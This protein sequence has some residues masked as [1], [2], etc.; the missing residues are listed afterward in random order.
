[1]DT[2]ITNQNIDFL[3]IKLANMKHEFKRL[4]QANKTKTIHYSYN[5][6]RLKTL[7]KNIKDLTLILESLAPTSSNLHCTKKSFDSSEA[8]WF[9]KP[10]KISQVPHF[11]TSEKDKD[12]GGDSRYVKDFDSII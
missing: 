7:E 2:V 11:Y 12:F 6:T 4:K 8:R 10:P 9:N 3:K 5:L 1:M